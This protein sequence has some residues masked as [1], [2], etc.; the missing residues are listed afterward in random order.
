MHCNNCGENMEGDG[1]SIVLHCPNAKDY[2]TS[3]REPDSLPVH[4]KSDGDYLVDGIRNAIGF[5]E[6]G[7]DTVLKIFQDDATRTFHA[8]AGSKEIWSNS[9]GELMDRIADGVLDNGE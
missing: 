5:V 6:N 9:F 7:S 4:C 1:Y 2:T 8:K 3:A